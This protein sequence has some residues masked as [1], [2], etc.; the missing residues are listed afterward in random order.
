[1]NLVARRVLP[2][3]EVARRGGGPQ[4]PEGVRQLGYAGMRRMG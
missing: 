1:V 2:L 4:A 3:T